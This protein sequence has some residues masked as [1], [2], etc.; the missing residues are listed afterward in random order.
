M[1]N[2]LISL[3][4]DQYLSITKTIMEIIITNIIC[5]LYANKLLLNYLHFFSLLILLSCIIIT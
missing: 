4:C 2:N 1:Y 5:I 3:N